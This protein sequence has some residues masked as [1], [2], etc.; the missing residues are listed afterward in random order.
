[1]G[2]RPSLRSKREREKG[3]AAALHGKRRELG[4]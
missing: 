3:V 4:S 1:M 2:E